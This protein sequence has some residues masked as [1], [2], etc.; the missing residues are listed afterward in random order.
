MGEGARSQAKGQ[1]VD[2][3]QAS[4]YERHI[5]EGKRSL[6]GKEKGKNGRNRERR[7]KNGKKR[8][9]GGVIAESSTQKEDKKKTFKNPER[10]SPNKRKKVDFRSKGQQRQRLTALINAERERS[11]R[12][13][14]QGRIGPNKKKRGPQAGGVSQRGNLTGGKKNGL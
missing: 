6:E 2:H 4:Q 14:R 8:G 7:A 10:I 11:S 1:D 12:R 13:R 3:Q 9:S 5:K